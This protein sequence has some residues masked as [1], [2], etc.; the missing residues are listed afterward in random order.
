MKMEYRDDAD[1]MEVLQGA[2]ADELAVLVDVITDGG[3]GRLVLD[4]EQCAAL[5]SARRAGTFRP[6]D[7]AS[8]AGAIQGF[9]GN[10]V[11]NLLRGGKGVAYR[12]VLC[13]VADHFKV[14]YDA[15]QEVEVIEAALLMKAL[16]QSLAG[17]SDAD[18]RRVFEEFGLAYKGFGPAAMAALIAAIRAS[19][20]GAYRMAAMVVPGAIRF[21]TGRAVPFAAMGPMMKGIS[22]LAGPVG[23]ALTGIWTAF[24]LASPAYRVTVPCV[25]QVAYLRQKMLLR[26]CPACQNLQP[27]SAKFC[28]ECGQ[29]F[30]TA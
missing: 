8:I 15:K 28:S 13:D 24:D 4:S 29:R 11:V 23:I 18:R 12:E 20:F 1:L 27:T 7:L 5:W 9:G 16:E 26:E 17:M 30:A 10:S 25:L 19:G 3:E 22:V 2:S 14:N 21:L 6:A